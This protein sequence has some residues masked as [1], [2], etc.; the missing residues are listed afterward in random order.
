[1]FKV[2]MGW[3]TSFDY[4]KQRR[5]RAEFLEAHGVN[6][7]TD[8]LM[9]AYQDAIWPQGEIYLSRRHSLDFLNRNASRLLERLV[10]LERDP[11]TPGVRLNTRY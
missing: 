5:E 7:R 2:S 1:M 8:Q 6:E 10:S 9:S 11:F 4:K 3:S